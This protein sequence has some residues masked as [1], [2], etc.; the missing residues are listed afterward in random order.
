M[1][2]GVFAGRLTLEQAVVPFPTGGFSVLAG[3]SGSGSLAALA[4]SRLAVL[5][6]DLIQLAQGFD[7]VLLDLGA[8]ID[9][10]VR[11]LA[12]C[13]ATRLVVITADPTSLTDAYAFIKVTAADD[14][15]ADQRVIVN[16]ARTIAEGERTHMTLQKACE[17]FLKL[18]PQLVGV[19]RRDRRVVDSIRTQTPLLIK[20]PDSD[21]ALDLEGIATR[22]AGGQR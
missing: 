5:A 15:S 21:A 1:S 8:G 13:A 9:R 10:M 19:V 7:H 17:T 2:S 18:T 22:L 11:L 4:P 20:F 12:A 3:R 14:P 6:A 16:Q